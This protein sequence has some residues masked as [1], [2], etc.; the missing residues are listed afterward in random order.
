MLA[1]VAWYADLT[2]YEYAFRRP[3][4]DWVVNV[5]WL[6]KSQPFPTGDVDPEV[7]ARL[8]QGLATGGHVHFMYGFHT[9]DFCR[10]ATGTAE[11]WYAL[12]DVIYAAPTMILHYIEAHHYRPPDVYLD[13][14]RYGVIEAVPPSVPN[15]VS[16]SLDEEHVE[17]RFDDGR[18]VRLARAAVSELASVPAGPSLVIKLSHYVVVLRPAEGPTSHVIAPQLLERAGLPVYVRAPPRTPPGAPPPLP[19]PAR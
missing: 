19:R 9:C 18:E 17:A 7:V 2:T 12:D 15:F 11:I 14:I 16:F 6:D 13:A 8:K 3:L 10:E 5:G 4:L 1:G